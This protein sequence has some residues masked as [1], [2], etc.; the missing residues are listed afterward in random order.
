MKIKTIVKQP[1][2]PS[3]NFASDWSWLKALSFP[4]THTYT[5]PLSPD[6]SAHAHFLKSSV[7]TWY[8]YLLSSLQSSWSSF[9]LKLWHSLTK[10]CKTNIKH[11]MTLY[12][13]FLAPLTS[14]MNWN[15]LSSPMY[16]ILLSSST[17][18]ALVSSLM[19]SPFSLL[20]LLV[21]TSSLGH[22]EFSIFPYS[23]MGHCT[24]R[25]AIPAPLPASVT[26]RPSADHV[27]TYWTELAPS[28]LVSTPQPSFYVSPHF[29]KYLYG[30][31]SLK[32]LALEERTY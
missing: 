7:V 25:E 22:S 27:M 32:N 12:R 29:N 15:L 23:H 17:Y 10:Y 8:W 19:H 30:I 18:S 1:V 2:T 31:F 28:A 16:W 6:K 21:I 13:S 11:H 5:Q 9:S 24:C 26:S 14:S 20:F 4:H 3:L